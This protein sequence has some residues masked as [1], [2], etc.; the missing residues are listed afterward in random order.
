MQQAVLNEESKDIDLKDGMEPDDLVKSLVR[1]MCRAKPGLKAKVMRRIQLEKDS[2]LFHTPIDG[3]VDSEHVMTD[4][5]LHEFYCKSAVRLE[6]GQRE[7][8][9]WTNVELYG[10]RGGT[11]DEH[12]H[13]LK[14]V[15]EK[16]KKRCCC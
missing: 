2:I 10:H 13:L 9:P 16:Q 12:D 4:W 3:P 14:S 6:K 11:E 1:V 8:L 7:K 15:E 5:H